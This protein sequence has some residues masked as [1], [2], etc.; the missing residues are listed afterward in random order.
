VKRALLAL[1]VVACERAEPSTPE[2]KRVKIDAPE[3]TVALD[4]PGVEPRHRVRWQVRPTVATYDSRTTMRYDQMPAS[5][6]ITKEQ[7]SIV[8]VHEDGVFRE[9]GM[10][11]DITSDP[12]IQDPLFERYRLL[13]GATF[14]GWVDTRGVPLGDIS[15]TI[16]ERVLPPD[17]DTDTS[18]SML[19][20]PEEAVGVGARWR[21]DVRNRQGQARITAELAAA[22]GLQLEIATRFEHTNTRDG[23]RRG[24]GTG[25]YRVNL[26]GYGDRS[27]STERGTLS[28]NGHD[29]GYELTITS[30]RVTP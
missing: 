24:T 23:T 9:A 22:D 6:V 16:D 4:D 3:V 1:A 17:Y 12:P 19:V 30:Q 14:S 18:T 28:A 15:A 29:V 27:T 2:R 26:Q 13:R 10:M 20:F 11:V 25:S 21:I 5:T 7:R 8:E